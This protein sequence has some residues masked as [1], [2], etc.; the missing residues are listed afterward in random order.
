MRSDVLY[1][2]CWERGRLD[3]SC[4]AAWTTLAWI[5]EEP[6]FEL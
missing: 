2:S 4:D 1:G 3:T 5:F 6:I